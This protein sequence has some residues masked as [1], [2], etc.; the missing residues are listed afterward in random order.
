MVSFQSFESLATAASGY[1]SPVVYEKSGN[2]SEPF[3]WALALCALSYMVLL[4]ITLFDWYSEKVEKIIDEKE[5]LDL[6]EGRAVEEHH[7]HPH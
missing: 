2:I 1:L 4:I 7:E 3:W 5:E 6:R